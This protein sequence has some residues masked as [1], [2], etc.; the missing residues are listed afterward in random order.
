MCFA[1]SIVVI[2]DCFRRTIGS[3]CPILFPY[4]LSALLESRSLARLCI[5]YAPCIPGNWNVD[6]CPLFLSLMFVV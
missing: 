2:G 5:V 3:L 4:L 1:A 6:V